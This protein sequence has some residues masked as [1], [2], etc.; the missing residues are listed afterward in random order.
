[1]SQGGSKFGGGSAHFD[2]AGVV[3]WLFRMDGHSGFPAKSNNVELIMRVS[4]DIYYKMIRSINI[5][6]QF[7]LKRGHKESAVC[8]DKSYCLAHLIHNCSS[9]QKAI[10]E[11]TTYLKCA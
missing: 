7:P 2:T 6:S 4:L 1:M 8:R 3:G 5:N 10:L 11:I 9:Y